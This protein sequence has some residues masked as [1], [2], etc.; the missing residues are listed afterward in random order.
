MQRSTGLEMPSAKPTK[1]ARSSRWAPVVA[2]GLLGG[3]SFA[4]GAGGWSVLVGATVYLVLGFERGRPN[5]AGMGAGATVGDLAKI[6]A[7][8]NVGLLSERSGS[9]RTREAW[10]ALEGVVCN[11]TDYPGPIDKR[12][13][14][15]CV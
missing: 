15:K 2:A 11:F 3:L 7:S 10:E 6:A 9:I 14:F 5:A 4:S 13:R 12:T 8:L 1:G